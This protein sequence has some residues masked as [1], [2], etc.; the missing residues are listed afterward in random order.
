MVF[1]SDSSDEGV[2]SKFGSAFIERKEHTM[3]KP[4]KRK[5]IFTSES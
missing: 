3:S 5:L 1:T 4:D 2:R